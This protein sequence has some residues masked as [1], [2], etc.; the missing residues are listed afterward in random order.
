MG[1]EIR[2]AKEADLGDITRIYNYAIE[3]T[4]STFDT[5][6]KTIGDRLQWFRARTHAYP[7][8]VATNDEQVVG[9][10]E[11]R[12]YGDRKAY[13]YSVED[14][15][16]V[17]QEHQSKG[18]ETALLQRIIEIA[19]EKRYHTMLALVVQGNTCST[20]LHQKFGFEKVGVMRQVGWKFDTWL[21][22]TIM[23]RLLI[24]S[25]QE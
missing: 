17:A 16:Y 4:T 9:W 11:I 12:R 8:I 20:M 7:I 5:E 23:Q 10:A 22:V 14:A 18:I 1:F 3:H 21:D 19:T 15:V 6:P 24:D 13:R 2:E 25:E